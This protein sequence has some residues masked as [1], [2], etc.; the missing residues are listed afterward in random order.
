[1]DRQ[2]LNALYLRFR[3]HG[4]PGALAEVFDATAPELMRVA[5]HLSRDEAEAEDILQAT[6]LAAIEGAARFD[7]E[8]NV[9]PW[10]VGILSNQV[11]AAR[12][13]ASRCPDPAR[14]RQEAPPDPAELAEE[15]ELRQELDGALSRMPAHYRD[16]LVPLFDGRRGTEIATE[17]D[18]S[19]DTVRTQ[20]DR[21]LRLLR[22]SLPPGFLAGSLFVAI[23]PRGLGAVRGA[24]LRRA[25]EA[26]APSLA[27]GAS[28]AGGLL[29]LKKF[30]WVAALVVLAPLIWNFLPEA[31][32][33]AARG[34]GGGGAAAP[35]PADSG[36]AGLEIRDEAA[37]QAE[38]STEGGAV[39]GGRGVVRD[40]TGAPVPGARV[41]VV[42]TCAQAGDPLLFET[43][44]GPGGAFTVPDD[45][46]P[47]IIFAEEEGL[48]RKDGRQEEIRFDPPA[49][50]KGA[51]RWREG[52][53][54]EGARVECVDRLAHFLAPE[55]AVTGPDGRF[56]FAATLP[57]QCLLRV[58]RPDSSVAGLWPLRLEPGAWNDRE[59]EIG[60]GADLEVTVR[61]AFSRLP[62]AGA[63]V[64]CIA[65]MGTYN[66]RPAL[67]R[68][69]LYA[70]ALSDERGVALV[71]GLPVSPYRLL[72]A[73]EGMA[74][75]AGELHVAQRAGTLVRSVALT[76]GCR[77]AGAV[78][79]AEGRLVPGADVWLETPLSRHES[80][81]REH[82]FASVGRIRDLPGGVNL[83]SLGTRSDELG[84]FSFADAPPAGD[85][86]VRAK[87]AAG[88]SGLSAPMALAPG[89][90]ARDVVLRLRGRVRVE[91][92][93]LSKGGD[94]LPAALLVAAAGA[95][96]P[97][98]IQVARG[99]A[100]VDFD[101][102][103]DEAHPLRIGV[104]AEG[105]ALA[106]FDLV[107]PPAGP[108]E[109]EC[110]LE[111]GEALALRILDE[112]ALPVAGALVKA[113]LVDEREHE[114]LCAF[115]APA[116]AG[117]SSDELWFEQGATGADGR[118]LLRGLPDAPL[119]VTVAERS[120]GRRACARMRPGPAENTVFLVS[121]P[122]EWA[123][124]TPG[125]SVRG[126]VVSALTGDPVTDFRAVLL[127]LNGDGS[128]AGEIAGKV[129]ADAFEFPLAPAGRMLRVLVAAQ[130]RAP[131]TSGAFVRS[132]RT[133][134][135]DPVSLGEGVSAQL[136][137][138]SS[139][140]QPLAGLPIR[141]IPLAPLSWQEGPIA[142]PASSYTDGA[143]MAPFEHL[144]PGSYR[145]EVDVPGLAPPN[146]MLVEVGDQ[147]LS[148]AIQLVP[149]GAVTFAFLGA[150]VSF[151]PYE[152]SAEDG[153]LV[154]RHVFRSTNDVLR[155]ALPE[156]I[157]QGRALGKGEAEPPLRFAVT[158]E[159]E[160]RFI[161]LSSL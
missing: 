5:R 94:P 51:V 151:V 128:L 66:G 122:A 18:R 82:V 68:F 15:R 92:R 20:I 53:A 101:L 33:D 118:L 161:V 39:A 3:K 123:G 148:G 27:G 67:D 140:S 159:S 63:L 58:K 26:A 119:L 81:D 32:P 134:S 23:E 87:D 30:I 10:L 112:H 107:P 150:G 105:Y 104:K 125:T 76:R 50:L 93:I 143:G 54:V 86:V 157:Y 14:L 71:E 117:R 121:S 110:Q 138:T 108:I 144:G 16:V 44:S 40:H 17:L 98:W 62:L 73:K 116:G 142:A 136:T 74:P 100:S 131:G 135:V 1:M 36:A 38:E 28:L 83:F 90:E 11:K 43:V 45:L 49:L 97:K 120:G 47:G 91:G 127:V 79:D 84:R 56:S 124:M 114:R 147:D 154:H 141:L 78:L 59:I 145:P 61:D 146:G 34:A 113:Y 4:E 2:E 88:Q 35:A 132:G 102:E 46:P 69:P 111:R 130:G 6:F 52:S 31:D 41:A 96:R 42:S 152:V 8:Q 160:Q 60:G 80:K 89:D 57:A 70:L 64:L 158:A 75:H 48:G 37:P 85:V 7:D 21:G 156:G 137:L 115:F 25:V 19:V 77:V 12:R 9:L 24:V 149:G 72:V 106:T 55:A 29:L 13:R 129:A 22:R 139:L 65:P 153:R 155:L 109:V 103:A 99:A 126:R 95:E 133:T